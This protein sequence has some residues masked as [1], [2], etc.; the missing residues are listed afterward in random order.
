MIPP[1]GTFEY[2]A[3]FTSESFGD[4]AV[5][6]H[7][8]CQTKGDQ[9]RLVGPN[10]MIRFWRERLVLVA[11]HTRESTVRNVSFPVGRAVPLAA[12]PGDRLYVVRT[13]S[14]GIGLSLLRQEKLVLAIGA[15]AEVP[16][17][18]G[19]E[20]VR[21]WEDTDKWQFV[22][23]DNSWLEFRVG[24]EQARLREREVLEIENCSIYV[25]RGW[26][27]GIPGIDECV[28]VCVADDP[29][30]KLESMRSAILLGNASLTI[31][32]WDCTERSVNQ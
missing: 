7:G 2:Q 32:D 8:E 20:A 11:Q 3:E 22:A 29:A 28:S 9:A 31:T 10:P 30:V 23:A 12:R 16:L 25:E 27:A 17:G 19:V 18:P 14:G 26:S 21:Y 5:V 4:N 6:V 24:K 15:V 13:G 1:S